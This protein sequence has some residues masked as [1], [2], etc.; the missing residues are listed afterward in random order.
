MENL[1]TLALSS[2]EGSDA[3]GAVGQPTVLLRTMATMDQIAAS[4]YCSIVFFV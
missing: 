1:F 4:N 2:E 3:T